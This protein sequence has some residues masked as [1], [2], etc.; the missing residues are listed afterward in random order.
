MFGSGNVFL[1]PASQGTGIIA[2]GPVR[3]VV[4]LAGY[5][6]I[7]SKSLGSRTPINMVRATMEGL[8]SL[9]T[10]KQVAELRDKKIEEIYG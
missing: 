8:A 10:A 5:S 9:K 7:L 2:G 1:R 3:A 4:E 6:D